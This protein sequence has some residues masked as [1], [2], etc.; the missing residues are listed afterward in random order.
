MATHMTHEELIAPYKFN[1]KFKNS[2]RDYYNYGFKNINDFKSGKQETVIKD[3]ERLNHILRDY[4]EWSDRS[5]RKEV[6]Y[7]TQDSEK[8]EE[9]PFH[10]LYR[11]CIYPQNNPAYFFHTMAAL[12]PLISL[13]EETE[14][15]TSDVK[16]QR[17][18]ENKLNIRSFLLNKELKMLGISKSKID[19]LGQFYDVPDEL[20]KQLESYNVDN[21]KQLKFEEIIT[22]TNVE[23]TTAELL[24]FFT[25]K[26]TK[27]SG[28]NK[29]KTSSDRLTELKNLGVIECK[30]NEGSKKYKWKI[31]SLTLRKLFSDGTK[32]NS[33]FK[34]HF[35]LFVDFFSKYFLFGEIG[36]FLLDR[37]NPEKESPFRFKHKYFMQSLNDVNLI[38][39][40]YGIEKQ[41]WCIVQYQHGKSDKKIEILCY[42]LEIRVSSVNGREYLMYYEP[43]KRSFAGLRIEFIDSVEYYT[44]DIILKNLEETEKINRN[45]IKHDVKNVK[46]SLKY[47]WG[48]SATSNQEK[49]AV[50]RIDVNT[51]KMQI[52]YDFPGE[53]YIRNRVLRERRKGQVSNMTESSL[54][55]MVKVSDINEMK[56]WIRS[57]YSRISQFNVSQGENFLQ[58]DIAAFREHMLKNGLEKSEYDTCKQTKESWKISETV[59]NKL[60]GK[61]IAAREHEKLFHEIFGVY[62]HTMA[63]VFLQLG[64]KG[65]TFTEEKL[66][67]M[68]SESFRSS[69]SRNFGSETQKILRKEIASFFLTKG[70]VKKV[71]RDMYQFKYCCAPETDFYQDIMPLTEMEIRWLKTAIKDKRAYCFFNEDEIDTIR[72]TLC[73]CAPELNPFPVKKIIYYD[74]YKVPQKSFQKEIEFISVICEEIEQQNIIYIKYQTNHGGIKTG[75]YMPIIVEFSKRNN[76]FQLYAISCRT[77]KITVIN[78]SSI[79]MIKKSKKTFNH[80]QKL[81]ELDIYRD[82]KKKHVDILFY[83]T[84]N[85][86]DRILTEFSPWEKNCTYDSEERIYKLR[87]YYQPADEADLTVRLMGYG[88]KIYIDTA[89]SIGYE[90]KKRIEKQSEMLSEN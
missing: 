13:Q 75:E 39:L 12:S 70:F 85:M 84:K 5:R 46:W 47:L 53:Y 60:K 17:Y 41:Y 15:L 35:Q 26:V 63:D 19:D 69:L 25:D 68:I 51:V 65:E 1:V 8:M 3:W 11:F 59:K 30:R 52:R 50:N 73:N 81:E 57:F 67:E 14:T 32:I 27:T 49:N 2:L 86:A 88:D 28:K 82:K 31:N 77:N 78:F 87:I 36:T 90:I 16:K 21:E 74:R 10:R 40:L 89:Q 44:E 33:D 6:M 4:V 29:N 9:N 23:L 45:D 18:L 24:Y 58:M 22:Q 43:F 80:S 83:D 61:G 37:I 20:I 7:I 72:K 55:Y 62:Y 79:L 38:D 66:K 76:R 64:V 71:D 34:Q 42:P 54:D 48:V 56:P